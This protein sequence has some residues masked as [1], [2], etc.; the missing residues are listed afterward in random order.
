VHVTPADLLSDALRADP[1]RPFLTFYDDSTGERV[2]LSVATF[3]NWVAK[4]A[5]LLQDGLGAGPGD[6][7]VVFLPTQWQAAVWLMAGWSCGLTVVPRGDAVSARVAVTG[8]D[9]LDAALAAEDV[10]ALSLR[11][12]GGRFTEPL[13]PGVLDYALEVPSYGDRFTPVDAAEARLEVDGM[14]Y[15]ADELVATAQARD[16][17]PGARVLTGRSYDTLDAVLDGLLSPLAV[18]GSVV[19]CRNLDETR[20]ERRIADERVTR[21][22]R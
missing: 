14:T 10:V 4:T 5:N 16:L 7:I 1:T 2:E 17:D 8:P 15:S 21:L 13:P 19:L 22:V 9:R 18:N 12:L 20:L 3:E 6:R 11:P